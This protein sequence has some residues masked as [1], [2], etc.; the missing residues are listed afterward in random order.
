MRMPKAGIDKISEL[1]I[2]GLIDKKLI[3]LK[4]QREKVRERIKKVILDELKKEEE[5]DKEVEAL[6]E[7]NIG[8]LK[9]ESIDYTKMFNMVKAK[10]A[11]EKGFIL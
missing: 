7:K 5:F 10:L 1:I 3:I 9:K 4:A 6:I 11:K 8:L 2:R